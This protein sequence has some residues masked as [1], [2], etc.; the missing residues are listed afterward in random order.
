MYRHIEKDE[1]KLTDEE[2]VKALGCCMSSGVC[3]DCPR[4][5]INC[6]VVD[7]RNGL[8]ANAISA[9]HRLQAENAELQK[10][11]DE[12][13]K[14]KEF[15]DACKLG[16][17]VSIAWQK[18]NHRRCTMG[19][20]RPPLCD[21]LAE[22][23]AKMSYRKIPENAVVLTREELFRDSTQLSKEKQIEIIHNIILENLD[24]GYEETATAIYDANYRKIPKLGVILPFDHYDNLLKTDK[25]VRKET[26]DEILQELL[27]EEN[28]ET[29]Y[30]TDEN[31][32][33]R[34]RQVIRIEKVKEIMEGGV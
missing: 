1:K 6:S 34:D 25:Q 13:K 22:E 28:L 19:V 29:V 14:Y 31:G 3:M 7:C 5:T 17:D 21:V 33:I 27:K 20:T 24:Y 11:V 10:Q 18:A 32:N 23:L 15:V 26:A 8:Y 12:L 2:I 16:V 30:F 4:N 9:I